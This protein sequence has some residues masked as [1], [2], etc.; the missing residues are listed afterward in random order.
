V[1]V[2]LI[3]LKTLSRKALAFAS[4]IWVLALDIRYS[5]IKVQY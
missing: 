1:Y 5:R 2:P 4:S 3:S